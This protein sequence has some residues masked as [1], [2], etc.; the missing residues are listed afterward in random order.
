VTHSV[1]T[2]AAPLVDKLENNA[3]ELGVSVSRL[4]NGAR[5]ID[6]GI[7]VPGSAE[8]GRLISEICMGGLG[9]VRLEDCSTYANTDWIVHVESHEPV[10]ACLAS[11][12]A[13]WSLSHSEGK[14]AFNALGSGPAR[15][16]GSH[17]DLFEELGY[18]DQAETACMV[19]EVDKI[20]P[21]ELA[22]KIASRCGIPADKLTLILTPT[23]SV[24]GVIQVVA[25]VLETALHKVHT[26]HFP[27]QTIVSG[28]G[29]APVCPVAKDFMTGMGRTNDAIL[30]AGEIELQIDAD[31]NA[32]EELAS[33]LPSNTSSDYGKLF[34]EV[35]KEVNY[36]FYKIDP[37]LFSPAKVTLTSIK[38]GKTYEAGEVN[39]TLLEKSFTS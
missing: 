33:Q 17:E 27:L 38:T 23:T 7:S 22:D 8:A 18:R 34:A 39:T 30:F 15:A 6:A 28:K 2:L 25:R 26:L 29:H 4:E 31:D 9:Q 36:D 12:Y 16:M 3:E 24:C 13:G 35:F 10:L 20:P 21:V 32:I 1:N 37:M 19:V 11:Q 14:G 5:I